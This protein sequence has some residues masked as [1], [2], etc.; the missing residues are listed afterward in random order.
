[1]PAMSARASALDT[2]ALSASRSIPRISRAPSASV[3][4]RV[5]RSNRAVRV[6][7]TPAGLRMC[8][9]G[10][11]AQSVLSPPILITGA[12]P[13]VR[14]RMSCNSTGLTPRGSV[15][16]YGSMAEY[17]NERPRNPEPIGRI[18]SGLPIVTTRAATGW[19]DPAA[20]A[21]ASGTIAA[22]TSAAVAAASAIAMAGQC[23]R[24]LRMPRVSHRSRGR[25]QHRRWPRLFRDRQG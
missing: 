5:I 18:G 2:I 14:L 24:C 15:P 20:P 19:P 11:Q 22:A 1:M 25:A 4:A 12:W 8:G 9:A 7:F 13:G 21:V 3:N 10:H 17:S 6:K 16:A 23:E